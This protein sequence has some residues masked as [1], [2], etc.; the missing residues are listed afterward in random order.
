[1]ALV[2]VRST[3]PSYF[4]ITDADAIQIQTTLMKEW[5]PKREVWSLR[6]G[7]FIVGANA[8]ISGLI[9]NSMFR[10]KL[11]LLHHG[12]I[13]T[14]CLTVAPVFIAT[15]NHNYFITKRLLLYDTDCSMCQYL[16]AI[17]SSQFA[18]IIFPLMTAPLIHLSIAVNLGFRVPYVTEV[19]EVLKFWWNTVKPSSKRLLLLSIGNCAIATVIVYKQSNAID[20]VKHILLR[21]Q[22]KIDD[23]TI[24]LK[25]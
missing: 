12:L 20:N 14:T 23:G 15:I 10:K 1:M 6:Y 7:D 19:R 21:I 18:S 3:A 9:I 25:K 4:E 11:K 24:S 8:G 17:S 16:K 5:E 2:P 22:E 13:Y